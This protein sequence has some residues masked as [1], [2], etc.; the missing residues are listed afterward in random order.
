L[1]KNRIQLLGIRGFRRGFFI[2]KLNELHDVAL[3]VGDVQPA[4][5]PCLRPQVL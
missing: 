1:H 3:Q 2:Q 5:L 4:D